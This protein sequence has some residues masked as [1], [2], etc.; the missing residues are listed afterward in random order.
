MSSPAASASDEAPTEAGDDDTET[1]AEPDAEAIG[2]QPGFGVA[3]ALAALGGLGYLFNYRS[4][5]PGEK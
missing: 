4:A 3:S 2:D 1:E 5:D